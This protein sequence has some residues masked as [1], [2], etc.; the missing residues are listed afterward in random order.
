MSLCNLIHLVLLSNVQLDHALRNEV[1]QLRRPLVPVRPLRDVD[2]QSRPEE[3]HVLLAQ[4][5][6]AEPLDSARRVSKG[7][8][9]PLPSA[10]LEIIIERGLSNSTEHR[11]AALAVRQLHNLVKDLLVGV[12]DD[13]VAAMLLG[14]LGLLGRGRSANDRGAEVLCHLDD[15]TARPASCGVHQD[16]IARLDLVG[17][18]HQRPG[19][20]A[21]QDEG[22]A[23]PVGHAIGKLHELGGGRGCILGHHVLGVHGDSVADLEVVGR[24][25]IRAELLYDASPFATG[26]CWECGRVQAGSKVDVD[27]ID[28]CTDGLELCCPVINGPLWPLDA[29]SGGVANLHSQF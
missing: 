28:T 7:D 5:Q 17:V 13:V 16:D 26:S 2:V 1:Q 24:R 15:Q 3:L 22:R 9:R 14:D 11:M 23:V 6:R 10:T 25:N 18:A 19:C 21:L 29:E 8:H 4:R 20:E 12:V 27:E